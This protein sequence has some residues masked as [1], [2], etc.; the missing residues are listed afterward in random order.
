MSAELREPSPESEY[1]FGHSD[2]QVFLDLASSMVSIAVL[3]IIFA[4]F[5]LTPLVTFLLTQKVS[6]WVLFEVIF[7]TCLLGI[8]AIWLIQAAHSFRKVAETEGK[9]I[10][11]LMDGLGTMSS[12]AW[13]VKIL[14][15]IAVALFLFTG[16]L[17]VFAQPANLVDEPAPVD[18]ELVEPS[19]AD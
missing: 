19:E 7:E 5:S 11:H 6:Y 9:D 8:V 13:L 2:N 1:E 4:V 18:Q 3:T 17:W 12:M 14:M 16:V 15:V 10:T